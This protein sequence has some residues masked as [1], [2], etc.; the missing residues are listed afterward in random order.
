MRRR[1]PPEFGLI[2]DIVR[3]IIQTRSKHL[4][5][6]AGREIR[7]IEPKHG[8]R[9][10][11]KIW[12]VET[13]ARNIF[14]IIYRRRAGT[15]HQDQQLVLGP[16]RMATTRHP[17]G[18]AVQRENAP[19]GERYVITLLGE[20]Q[21]PARVC[22]F[23]QLDEPMA[24]FHDANLPGALVLTRPTQYTYN[25]QIESKIN[26]LAWMQR[27]RIWLQNSRFTLSTEFLFS[28]GSGTVSF[29]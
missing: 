13:D 4:T 11:Q 29:K 12:P 7:E 2:T 10:E 25:M 22:D 27:S 28:C 21:L 19:H 9:I 14:S 17:F 23:L 16:M 5:H 24:R 15:S 8:R 3:F 18:Y 20:D 6:C 1:E 26:G